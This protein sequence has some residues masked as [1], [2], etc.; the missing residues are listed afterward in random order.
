MT[1]AKLTIEPGID[2]G[3]FDCNKCTVHAEDPEYCPVFRELLD[4]VSGKFGEYLRCQ[5]CLDA[6][7]PE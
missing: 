2:V 1:K 5:A 3:D 6:E 4:K 7:V